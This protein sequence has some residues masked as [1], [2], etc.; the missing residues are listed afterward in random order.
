MNGLAVVDKRIPAMSADSIQ[1]VE[2]LESFILSLPQIE[3]THTHTLHDGVYTRTVF[4]PATAIITG[5][6]IKIPTTVIISGH[7]VAYT[8]ADRVEIIGYHVIQAEAGRKQAFAAIGDT[9]ITMLFATTATSI[10]ESEDQFTDESGRLMTR[11]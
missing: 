11:G 6:L 8:G 2:A 10:E 3:L 4:L 5:A 7:V 9:Y 1:K